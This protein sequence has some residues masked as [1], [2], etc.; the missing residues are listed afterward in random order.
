MPRN[1][2][3]RARMKDRRL[4]VRAALGV[5]LA[6]NLAAA[7]FA[8]HP[9]GGS[10]G[11]LARELEARQRDLAQMLQRLERTRNV[12]EKVKQAREEGDRFI[13]EY[14]LNRRT[15]YSTLIG[16]V[17]K[18][19]TESGMKPKES[20]Y[21]PPEPVE[22][23]ETLEQLTITGSYEGS[24]QSLTKFV[25]MLDKSS[26]FLIIDGMQAA[27][28]SNGALSVTVKLDTFIQEARGG[29]S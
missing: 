13:G 11:D 14:V 28:Q 19:A 25:N 1:F 29:K 18:L 3:L 24:Y 23:S 7:V 21:A 9:L 8:F 26:R 2:D 16:E 27:P 6:A 12:V 10:A 17:N 20:A 22:G 5:L 4:M 15:A